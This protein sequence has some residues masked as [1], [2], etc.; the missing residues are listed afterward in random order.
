MAPEI[1]RRRATDRRVDI[2]ALGVSVYRLLVGEHPWGSTETTGL[3]ALA[4]D[5]RPTT[6]ILR[7]RPDLDP[8]MAAAVHRCIEAQPEKR[9]ESVNQFLSAIRNIDPRSI[10]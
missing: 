1:I 5:A 3:A 9:F 6:D 10:G 4:H 7:F 2:F 8:A